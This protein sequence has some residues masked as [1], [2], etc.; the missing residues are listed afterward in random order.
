MCQTSVHGG[1]D[2]E[3][4][5]SLTI[6]PRQPLDILIREFVAPV[7]PW[8]SRALYQAGQATYLARC[9]TEPRQTLSRAH[10]TRLLSVNKI[11]ELPAVVMKTSQRWWLTKVCRETQRPSWIPHA[12]ELNAKMFLLVFCISNKDTCFKNCA[13]ITQSWLSSEQLPVCPLRR[14]WKNP[15]FNTINVH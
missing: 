14:S 15:A 10:I 3:R 4:T 9:N 13:I 5:V 2:T 8:W 12:W 11:N 1:S 6:K 7:Q